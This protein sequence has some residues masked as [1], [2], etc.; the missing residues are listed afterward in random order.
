MLRE[1]HIS[2]LGVIEELDLELHPGLNVLTGETGAGKTMV[3]VGLALALGRRASVSL[4]RPGSGAARVQAVFDAPER[5]VQG[6]WAEDGELVLARSVTAEGRSAARIGGQL[7]PVSALAELAADLVEVHGQHE[8]A[9]LLSA[10]AQTAFLDRFAGASHAGAVAALRDEHARLR[11]IDAERSALAERERDREREL[12]LLAYQVREIEAA[13]PRPGE[14]EELQVEEARLAN[15]ERLLERAAAAERLLSADGA[16]AD[17]LG[18]AAAELRPAAE[19][20]PR[21]QELGTRAEELGAA[22]AE[23]AH[24][25]R[26]YRERVDLDPARLDE[27]RERIGALKGLAAQVRRERGGGS[28]LPRGRRDP[29]RAARRRRAG[30]DAPRG[31]GRRARASASGSLPRRSR[32][33]GARRHRGSRWRSRPSSG[34][35]GCRGPRSRSRSCRSPRRPRAATSGSSSASPAGPA[36]PGCRSRAWPPAASSRGRCSPAGACRWTSTTCR[37]SSSTRSTPASGAARASRWGGGCRRSRGPGR[38]SSS[39]TCRRSPR[40]PTATSASTSGAGR[41][42]LTVLDDTGRVEELTR[43]L[44]G[45][46]GS[47]AAATHAEELLAEAGRAR[48]PR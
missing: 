9:R 12:D 34:S 33:D 5:A 17:A 47:E 14:L 42:P 39:P 25:L 16:A 1:L 45:L 48:P 40:S 41:R 21:A 7:A 32:A 44:A 24:D 29:G 30:A 26:A 20:D 35:W 38:S 28:R 8:G 27:V 37:R 2:G 10:A 13:S 22:A 18:A 43:M 23:L 19:I 31:R 4:V 46:P 15:A 3:T 11:A 36:S 6:G